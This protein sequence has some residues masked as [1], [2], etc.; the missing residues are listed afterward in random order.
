MLLAGDIGGTKTQLGIFSAEKGLRCP[1]VEAEYPSCRYPDLESIL[2]EFLGG[3]D[4][5]LSMACFSVAGPV[6][7]GRARITNLPWIIDKRRLCQELDLLKVRIVNDIE[8]IAYALPFLEPEDLHVLNK[9]HS[10]HRGNMAVIAP[11][12]GLGEAFLTWDG[13]RYHVHPS[14]G[15]HADFAPC[16]PLEGELLSYLQERFGHVSYERVCSGIGI[17]NIYRFLR[18]RDYADEPSWL[19]EQLSLTEEPVPVIVNA[20]LDSANRCD[21]CV[22][23]IELFA[24]I[25]GAEAGNMLLK[26]LATKGIYLGGGIPRRILPF[27]ESGG[28]MESFRRKGRMADLVAQT[29]V[30]VILHPKVA[31]FGVACYCLNTIEIMENEF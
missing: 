9:G 13:L 24:S 15:G 21:L 27:L 28:F 1:L 31:L 11:G 12:T 10:P 18:D 30:F 26:V 8:A 20:A 4:L 6:V 29:P 17:P 2:R 3:I 5:P 25:L 14:E 19:I 16:S 23:S 22:K 7:D